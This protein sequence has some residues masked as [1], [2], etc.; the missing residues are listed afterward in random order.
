MNKENAIQELSKF[1]LALRPD[2][3]QADLTSPEIIHNGKD[4]KIKMTIS[5]NFFSCEKSIYTTVNFF[6]E[7]SHN[8]RLKQLNIGKIIISFSLS[9]TFPE[10]HYNFSNCSSFI[11]P[12]LPNSQSNSDIEFLRFQADI[13]KMITEIKDSLFSNISLSLEHNLYVYNENMKK[14]DQEKKRKRA[15]FE[16][17]HTAN[18]QEDI[19]TLH[20][21][22]SGGQQVD[23]LCLH[24]KRNKVLFITLQ[25]LPCGAVSC[26]LGTSK[27][28][29][30]TKENALEYINQSIQRIEG[31]NYS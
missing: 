23:I 13:I 3:S 2:C 11:K 20:E 18:T 12:G 4:L 17:E 31:Y 10:I 8:P 21:K 7:N 9:D 28:T 15:A 1:L 19:K 22:L 30:I 14:L 24:K 27:T 16:K 29:K 6:A 25:K 26:S 5:T